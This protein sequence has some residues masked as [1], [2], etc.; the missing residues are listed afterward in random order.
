MPYA[1]GIQS[2][3]FHAD[4]SGWGNALL[5][6]IGDRQARADKIKEDAKSHRTY[7]AM[8]EQLGLDT[9]ELKNAGLEG[10]KG[11]VE[12]YIAKSKFEEIAQTVAAK[13]AEMQNAQR[14]AGHVAQFQRS[15]SNMTTP[16]QIP[17]G[18]FGPLSQPETIGGP[19]NGE[20]KFNLMQQSGVSPDDQYKLMRAYGEMGVGNGAKSD[21]GAIQYDP[22]PN[23]PGAVGWRRGNMAGIV[24]DPTVKADAYS[25]NRGQVTPA[26]EFADA[27]RREKAAMDALKNSIII[28]DP[29]L[30]T[31]WS[32]E[33]ADARKSKKSASG[34]QTTNEVQPSTSLDSEV[35]RF[36][37]DGRAAIFDSKSKKFLRYAD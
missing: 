29:E 27:G 20:D 18:T 34:G 31:Y 15:Y 35:K 8:G 25:K 24:Q 22:V 1:P 37:S 23:I 4:M 2:V 3:P 10:A 16:M 7:M 33:L 6:F 11:M 13:R 26:I 19:M 14:D 32:T 9:G 28:S 12:G 21:L 30:K 17:A 36:T 5:K